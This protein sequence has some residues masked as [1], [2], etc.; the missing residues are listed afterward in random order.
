MDLITIYNNML[1]YISYLILSW[2]LLFKVG[3]GRAWQLIGIQILIF[4]ALNGSTQVHGLCS[5]T[6]FPTLTEFLLIFS[7]VTWWSDSRLL[8]LQ[9]R[10]LLSTCGQIAS[11]IAV[12]HPSKK[13]KKTFLN[14]LLNMKKMK[15]LMEALVTRDKWLK[16]VKQRTQDGGMNSRPHLNMNTLNIPP[17]FSMNLKKTISL[18]YSYLNC[19]SVRMN[20]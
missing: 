1:K 4:K 8:S 5:S 17:N 13:L 10:A 6:Y 2:S 14:F 20:S 19:S 7:E 18:Q 11:K 15:K 9:Q 3:L 12:T 16:L